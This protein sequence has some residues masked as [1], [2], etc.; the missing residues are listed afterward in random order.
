MT[1]D[2]QADPVAFLVL[3]ETSGNQSYIFSTNR[4]KE[5][6]GASELTY[7]AGTRWIL[8]T[9]AAPNDEVSFEVWKDSQ[10]VRELLQD[11]TRNPPIERKEKPVEIIVATSGKALILTEDEDTARNLIAEV[12][13][14]ALLEAPGL[15]LGGVYHPIAKNNFQSLFDGVK[16]V[17]QKFEKARSRRP[18]PENRFLRLPII[19]SC[20]VS[21]LPASELETLSQKRIQAGEKPQAISQA[22]AVKRSKDQD[23]KKRLTRLDS[24]LE[25]QIDR[26]IRDEESG[27][28]D[29][30]WLGIV[31]ADG[32]GLGQI[33]LKFQDYIGKDQSNRNYINKYREFSLALDEC[34]EKA[35]KTALDVF[36]ENP[37]KKVAPIVPLIIGG[38]DLTVVCDGQYALEFTR[39][40]L[41]QF[42]Q[43]TQNHSQVSA[44]A[45]EV[46][47]ADCLSA[48]AGVAIVKRHFPFSVAYELAESLIKSAKQVKKRV[49][50]QGD[51][52][53]PC[54]AIDFHILYD[55]RCLELDQIREQFQ[56][57]PTTQLYNRPYVVS[58]LDHLKAA[59][60]STWAENHHWELLSK[61]VSWLKNN[62]SSQKEKDPISSSQSHALRTALFLGKGEADAQ[63]AL[64]RQRYDLEKFAE[65]DDKT[66]LFYQNSEQI[67][68]TS[69]LDALDAKDFLENNQQET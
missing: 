43:E 54:S 64:I 14:K 26:L 11:S 37:K 36:P 68:V 15:D 16:Q 28:E 10:R 23:A 51:T 4:L 1:Q 46:F 31:H 40:F 20:A 58:S 67:H 2:S 30:S 48:C 63:Y 5:N 55:S 35:F 17:H 50:K 56:P 65:S 25:R 61:R 42:E 53:F 21:G 12:S 9:V 60:D 66:S 32:N 69:F 24:R 62:Q 57:E 52:P 34:T 7:Q 45:R 49:T 29:R 33:F 47:E 59:D 41:E 38:D 22:S 18:F 27:E 19:A 8:E 13:R 6:I 3:L 39:V 44:I